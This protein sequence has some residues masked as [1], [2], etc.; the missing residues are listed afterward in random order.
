LGTETMLTLFPFKWWNLNLMGNLYDYRVKG[1][2]FD[3][4]IDRSSFNW[5]FRINNTIRLGGDYRI[6]FSAN[7]ESPSVSSQ[8]R[9]EAMFFTNAAIRRDFWNRKFTATLQVRDI[10]GSATRKFTTKGAD[11]YSVNQFSRAPRMLSI[12]LTY[13][14]NN[15]K[16]ERDNNRH[17]TEEDSSEFL[18]DSGG[19]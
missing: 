5:S 2:L 7:Y 16:A 13:N 11:F 4:S 9:R 6:Q 14:I 3:E 19:Y 12:T 1:T 10:L 17:Q 18:E 8:G 15:Y